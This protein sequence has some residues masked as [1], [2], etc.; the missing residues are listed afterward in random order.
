MF[1]SKRAGSI[2][3]TDLIFSLC[4]SARSFKVAQIISGCSEICC[5]VKSHGVELVSTIVRPLRK[6]TSR[7]RGS[8]LKDE[9][10]EP[11]L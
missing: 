3:A 2:E 8:S 5:T 11:R 1:I 10:T 4:L 9:Q 7:K 6:P